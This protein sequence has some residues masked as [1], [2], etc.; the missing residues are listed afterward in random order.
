MDENGSKEME[1]ATQALQIEYQSDPELT[2]FT[3]LDQE[4]FLQ[5][6]VEA[7]PQ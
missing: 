2:A 1:F 5:R 3:A 7:N 6:G 4:D